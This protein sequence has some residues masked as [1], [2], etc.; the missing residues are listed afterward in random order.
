MW[1]KKNT[2]RKNEPHETPE[3]TQRGTPRENL[4]TYVSNSGEHGNSSILDFSILE[5]LDGL[6]IRILQQFGS[7]GRALV[8]RLDGGSKGGIP[9][10]RV[11]CRRGS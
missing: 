3:V 2:V 11:E 7:E 6:G 4:A 9:V 8:G 10:H 1:W 5:P